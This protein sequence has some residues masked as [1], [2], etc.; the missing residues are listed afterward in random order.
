ML[1][2]PIPFSHGPPST[3]D[4]HG[5]QH[6]R[7]NPFPAHSVEQ[8]PN[9]HGP[10]APTM[11]IGGGWSDRLPAF[12]ERA[13]ASN[14]HNAVRNNTGTNNNIEQQTEAEAEHELNSHLMGYHP[15]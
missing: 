9:G 5:Q 12:Q 2:H 14:V 11:N 8:N 13:L 10:G 15:H 7:P 1:F 3:A 6:P 4:T